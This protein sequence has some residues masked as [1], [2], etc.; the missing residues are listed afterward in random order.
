M[1]KL[2]KLTKVVNKMQKA[3]I[4]ERIVDY[5]NTNPIS[6]HTPG[7]KGGQIIPPL[8]KEKW[9]P[10]VWQ[11][12]VTELM[13]LD[14]LHYP[15]GCIKE[16]QNNI[17]DLANAKA[18]YFLVNGTSV[19]IQAAIL[20]LGYNSPIFVPRNVHKS[21]YNAIILANAQPIYLPIAFDENIGIPLGLNVEVLKKY[22]N[23]YPQCKTIVI[24][25]PTYQGIS[26]N[27]QELVELALAKGL[28][29]IC[30]EAHG[31]HFLFH[32]ELP[33]SALSLGAHIVVQSWHKTLPVLTQASI[34]HLGQNYSGPDISQYLNLLQ[35][36]SPSYLLMASLDSCQAFLRAEIKDILALAIKKIGSFKERISLLE[37]LELYKTKGN[38][39][40]DPFKICLSSPKVSGFELAKLLREKYQIYAELAEENFCLLLLGIVIEDGTL[41]KLEE[42]LIE[43]NRYLDDLPNS[44]APIAR[45]KMIIP[46]TKMHLRE[47]FFSSKEKVSLD[48]AL[49]RICGDY[50]IEYPPGVPLLVPGEVIDESILNILIKRDGKYKIDDEIIVVLE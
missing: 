29:I 23:K 13:N 17:A 35:T 22:I 3:P 42:G 15:T 45:D 19:G 46:T 38:Q 32:N 7:H 33:P 26:C 43:I 31:S 24:T 9:P 37:N 20:A 41:H 1:I 30:D 50:I 4:I 6:C 40:M 14:N 25:N 39:Q 2:K 48:S 8:L 27:I 10:E 47:A 18:S 11:Y 16:A 34:L 36:T 44:Y 49:G 28:K 21:V 12:D 5:L